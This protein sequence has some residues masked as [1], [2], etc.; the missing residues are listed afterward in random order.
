MVRHVLGPVLVIGLLGPTPLDAEV[1]VERR[2]Q[3]LVREDVYPA[4]GRL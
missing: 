1:K 4:R 2:E 3:L